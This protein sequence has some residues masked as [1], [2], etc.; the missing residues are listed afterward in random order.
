MDHV[1][2]LLA[3][4]APAVRSYSSGQVTESC[5]DLRPHHSGSSPQRDTAPFTV[6]T[7]RHSYRKGEEVTVQLQALGSTPFTGFLLQA[8][9]L[10]GWAPVGSFTA[11]TGAAQL[12]TCTSKPNSAVSHTSESLKTSIQ[13]KWRAGAPEVT[14]LVQFHASFVQNY[15]TFWVDVTSPPLNVTE[16]GG[17][18]GDDDGGFSGPAVTVNTSTSISSA[19]CGITKMCFSQ[20]SLCDPEVNPSCFFMS[21]ATLSPSDAAARFEMTGP[22]AGY[23]SFGFS[24]DQIMGDDDIYICGAS[25][26]GLVWLQHAVSTGRTVPRALPLGNVSD[27]QASVRDGVISCAFTSFNPVSTQRTTG[28]N[29]TYYLMFAHGPSSTTGQIQLHTGTFIS[30]DKVHISRPQLVGI[31]R[32]PHIIRAH[33]ALMLLAWMTT[34]SLGMMAARYLRGVAKG[35]SLAGKDV[36]F[37]VHVVVMGVTVA[38]TVT[39]F[40]LPFAY[41]QAW[42]GGAHPVLGCLVLVL[43]LLQPIL[44]LL[45]CGPQHPL[46]FLFDWSHAVIAAAIKVLAVAAIF[47]GLRLIDSTPDQWLM[48][49][50]GGLVGWEASFCILLEVRFKCRTEDRGSLGSTTVPADVLLMALFLLGNVVFLISLLVGIGTS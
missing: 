19:D 23:V 40:I 14:K 2:L 43:S 24:D 15:R 27:V 44:A 6:T 22:S 41:V 36:W 18:E 35:H 7:D 9:E 50:L 33:G 21:V 29:S 4:L 3:F 37:V 48:K 45:R 11:T 16:G 47:T 8:R 38:A 49:V 13:V 30:P 17:D 34:G 5:D 1:V 20:P 28:F 12:L 32:W 31:S 42:S 39:A 26:S 25:S 46:R 10:G